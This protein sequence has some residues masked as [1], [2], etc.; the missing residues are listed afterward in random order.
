MENLLKTTVSAEDTREF[1]RYLADTLKTE[2]M[3]TAISFL[4]AIIV[5]VGYLFGAKMVNKKLKNKSG[6]L[7]T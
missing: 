1:G 6:T 4:L 3:Q 2:K 5:T 7:K